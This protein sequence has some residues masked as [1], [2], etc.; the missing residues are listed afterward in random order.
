MARSFGR[1]KVEVWQS[2]S[3]FRG[4]TLEQQAVYVML[5]S[6][7]FITSVGVLDYDVRRWARLAAG[8]EIAEMVEIIESLEA[9]DYVIVDRDTDE[10]LVRSFIK[11]N[12]PWK[13]PNNLVSARSMFRSVESDSIRE[14][15][16]QRHPWLAGSGAQDHEEIDRVE[17]AQNSSSYSS[18]NYS[19][20]SSGNSSS[21]S[22]PN[23]MTHAREDEDEY[24]DTEGRSVS[25]SSSSAPLEVTPTSQEAERGALPV[26]VVCPK[27]GPLHSVPIGFDLAQHLSTV[28]GVDDPEAM[29]ASMGGGSS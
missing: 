1:V 12:E 14:Y 9:R 28:H 3:D 10:L 22:S 8:V 25:S 13:R 17:A 4:L 21:D 15:L 11:H 7:P 18:P 20:D 24:E 6:Q 5:I 19:K 2:G 16:E 26:A 27:C 23:G 29:L